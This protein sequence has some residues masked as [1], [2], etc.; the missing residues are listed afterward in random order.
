MGG[1]ELLKCEEVN[2]EEV[3]KFI[4]TSTGTPPRRW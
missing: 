4:E 2:W 1:H 3:V